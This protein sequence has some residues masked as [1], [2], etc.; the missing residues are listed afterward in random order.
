MNQTD[1]HAPIDWM[2][3]FHFLHIFKSARMAAAPGK[4]GLAALALLL[5]LA[6]GSLL[7][8]IWVS[9]GGG[10]KAEQLRRS[11]MIVPVDQMEV[12]EEYGPFEVLATHEEHCVHEALRAA[13][14]LQLF[15]RMGDVW[16]DLHRQGGP[17]LQ[18]TVGQGYGACAMIIGMIVGLK[19]IVLTSWSGLIFV[20]L[21]GVLFLA[22][23]A[24]CGG[25]ICRMSALEFARDE[26]ISWRDA[27]SYS[28][29]RWKQM[30]LAPVIVVLI[31]VAVAV[32]LIIGGW[33]LQIPAIGWIGAVIFPF[34]IFGGVVIALCVLGLAAGFGLM[35]P[36]LA[37]DGLDSTDAIAR[38]PSYV[39]EK[40]A[41]AAW[42]GLLALVFGAIVWMIVRGFAFLVLLATYGF[43]KMGFSELTQMWATPTFDH[44]YMASA[45]AGDLEGW[46]QRHL[47][48]PL[49][50]MWVGVFILL[51][52]GY[53]VSYFF[54]VSTIIYFLLRFHADDMEFDDIHMESGDTLPVPDTGMASAGGSQFVQLGVPS[55]AE[56]S[57]D[58][59]QPSSQDQ[60]NEENTTD[61]DSAQEDQPSDS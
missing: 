5:T 38:G 23:W 19:W 49:I 26:H 27:W 3:H 22:I 36:T 40:P 41:H 60:A 52:N 8:W 18:P 48:L 39:A 10:Y 44:F 11:P 55:Q 53:L 28:G 6:A 61:S 24:R 59:T 42:Y 43:V 33:L 46:T 12:G 51:V 16:R 14:K 58:P 32:M 35:W 2:R 56:T 9:A 4:L 1:Q 57:H 15:G 17:Q 45:Q 37:V 13:R 34:A 30:I 50:Q 20:L 31:A 7:D 54:S 29:Q 47:T 25:A 21:F